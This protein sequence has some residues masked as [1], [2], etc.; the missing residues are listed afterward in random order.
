LVPLF[1][2]SV[3]ALFIVAVGIMPAAGDP[4]SPHPTASITVRVSSTDTLWAIAAA[5]RL[6]GLST[7][8]MV[9]VIKDTNG[10][11]GALAAGAVL[12]V[13]SESIPAIAYAQVN[14]S[15]QVN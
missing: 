9:R 8:Q 11:T 14:D 4:I 13:P 15:G 3:L 2:M 1:W 7:A 12:Q 5:H 6:P 10:L